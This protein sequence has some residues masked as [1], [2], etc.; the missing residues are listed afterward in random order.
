[1]K[2]SI[3][4]KL[5]NKQILSQTQIQSLEILTMDTMELETFLNQEYLENPLLEFLPG[6]GSYSSVE[7]YETVYENTPLNS[8]FRYDKEDDPEVGRSFAA[9]DKDLLKNHLLSQLDMKQFSA[10]DWQLIYFLIGN[11]EEDGYLRMSAKEAAQLTGCAYQK[12]EHILSVLRNLEPYGI[13][14][15]DLASSLQKQIEMMGIRDDALEKIIACYLPEVADGKISVISRELNLTTA[16]VR[17][18]ISVIEKLNPKPLSGFQGGT[19]DYIVP[20]IIFEKT[21]EGFEIQI[22]DHWFG[23]YSVS[24]YYYKMMQEAKDEELVSYFRKKLERTRLVLAGVEQRRETLL[25]ISQKILEKQRSYFEGT[26]DLRPLTMTELAEDLEIHPSTVSRAVKGKFLQFPKGTILLKNVFESTLS[27]EGDVSASHV[28]E[29]IKELV[30]QENKRKPYSDAK[31]VEILQ[32]EGIHI[33]RRAV[34]KYRDEMWIKS[35][36]ERKIR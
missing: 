19:A 34:A 30:M 23:E 8:H 22:N 4:M 9:P 18:Y 28:K 21:K 13:F 3:G 10:E 25:A 12:M 6:N 33:S 27:A 35:S 26:G 7:Q 11:L 29:R 15:P 20:D 14:S 24:D 2:M 17:K 5:E 36:F 1:M 16:E 31:I 32:K